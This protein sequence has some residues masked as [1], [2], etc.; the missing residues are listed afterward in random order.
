M[1]AMF[2]VFVSTCVFSPDPVAA[3][4]LI[5]SRSGITS[6]LVS[7]IAS[8]ASAVRYGARSCGC[9]AVSALIPCEAVANSLTLWV[10]I[11]PYVSNS[12]FIASIWL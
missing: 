12:L 10:T 2:S 6:C 8:C 5:V 1:V 4:S 9:R 7:S 3:F 11:L